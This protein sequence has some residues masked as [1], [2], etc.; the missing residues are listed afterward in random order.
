MSNSSDFD[1]RTPVADWKQNIHI[2]QDPY[3]LFSGIDIDTD[4]DERWQRLFSIP[5]VDQTLPNY[6]SNPLWLREKIN[7]LSVCLCLKKK[8][9]MF[10][11]FRLS[12]VCEKYF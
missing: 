12:L 6:E 3:G 8:Q 5:Y 9:K 10:D 7:F 11:L 2:A 1:I 4:F